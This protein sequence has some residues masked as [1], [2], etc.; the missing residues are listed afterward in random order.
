[1]LGSQARPD[2]YLNREQS[3]ASVGTSKKSMIWDSLWSL[4]LSYEGRR[5]GRG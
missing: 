1:M 3:A 2:R 5:Q 4:D